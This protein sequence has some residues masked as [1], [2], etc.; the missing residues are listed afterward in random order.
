MKATLYDHDAL[1]FVW[2]KEW[3][4]LSAEE[5]A[6]VAEDFA[7]IGEYRDARQYRDDIYQGNLAS[8]VACLKVPAG[9]YDTEETG[10]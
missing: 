5:Q 4:A 9:F 6:L 7:S 1:A 8:Y 3:H 10:P 2:G